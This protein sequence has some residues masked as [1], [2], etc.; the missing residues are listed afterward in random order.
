LVRK[1]D[2]CI[3]FALLMLCATHAM[4][5]SATLTWDAETDP[6]VAGY[7]LY[8]GTTSHNYTSKINV[9]KSTSHVVPNLA[10]GTTYYY[11]VTAYD[12][13]LVES[14]FS[15]E[16]S[17]QQPAGVPV[18]QFSASTTSGLAPLA[19]NFTDGSTGGITSWSWKFGDGQSSSTRNPAHVYSNAGTYTVSLTVTGPGGTDTQT[20]SNYI[21]V[22]T[23]AAPVAQFSATP[24][25]GTAPLAVGFTDASTGGVTAWSWSFG[26][27]TTSTARN[28]SHTYSAAGSYTVSLTVT[29]SGKT[30]SQTRTSYIT[31]SSSTSVD[32]TPPAAPGSLVAHA[33][34]QTAISLQWAPS[35]DNVGV[36][37]YLV[38]RCTGTTCS[39]FAQIGSATVTT[40]SNIRLLAGTTYRYR[41]RAVDAAGN[42]SAYSNVAQATTTGQSS[43]KTAP[44]APQSLVATPTGP[45]AITLTWKAS[46]DNNKVSSY[47]IERC[48][49]P[50][51]TSFLLNA[52]SVVPTYTS[53]GLLANTSYSFR[54]RALDAAGNKSAYS[55]V[56][57]GKATGGTETPPPGPASSVIAIAQIASA[58]P[59]SSQS[60]VSVKLAQAQ[61]AGNLNVV[62]VGWNDATSA[63]ASVTDSRGN[64]YSRVAGPTSVPGALSQSIYYAKNITGAAAGANTV[65]VKFN[66]PARFVDL[67]VAEYSGLD[68]QYPIVATSVASG[69]GTLTNS[70]PATVTQA[71]A[72]LFAATTVTSYTTGA[73]TGFT[74]RLVTSPDSDIVEDRVVTAAGSYS[75]T[76]AIASGTWVMQ[77]VAFKAAP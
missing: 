71:P 11:A 54:V 1:Y 28:P 8:Y 44:S 9:G 59:Q 47:L 21:Q 68:R 18:A 50:G 48:Q 51:C 41:V 52:L 10:D 34:S 45:N 24:T 36:K 67:R 5:G 74:S 33:T 53:P 29:G 49:G 58:V 26:D 13:S 42:R 75:A 4:A 72:L 46:T 17:K 22:T 57:T 30:N 20:K 65:T 61:S 35:K 70:G 2:V 64:V 32:K 66:A 77:L 7:M 60:T 37:T 63:V 56:A 76:S 3:A 43:D 19:L 55:N 27:G 6:R 62:V 16:V 69:S 31:V 39:T 12:A 73:G 40:Y 14:G 38:E 25:S 23:T 15:T